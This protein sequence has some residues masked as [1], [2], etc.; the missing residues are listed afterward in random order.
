M[1]SQGRPDGARFARAIDRR[2]DV[3]VV[4]LHGDAD[5]W[6]PAA[7]ARASARWAPE[8]EF[9]TVPRAGH[10]PHQEAPRHVTEVL[11]RRL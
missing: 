6:V 3:P 4:S 1:R 9:L 5:P 7:V 10:F 8:H 2:V 11:L